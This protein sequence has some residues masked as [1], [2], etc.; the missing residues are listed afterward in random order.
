MLHAQETGK[1]FVGGSIGFEKSSANS[2]TNGVNY[3][4]PNAIQIFT[5][6]PVGGYKINK[7]IAAGLQLGY[8]STINNTIDFIV[9]SVYIE[10]YK[11]YK[12]VSTSYGITIFIRYFSC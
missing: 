8:S 7:L 4:N 9:D 11:K 2:K 1:Y 10:G 6:N 12:S 3:S 5:F